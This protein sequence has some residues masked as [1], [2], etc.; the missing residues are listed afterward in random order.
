MKAISRTFMVLVLLA[1]AH[2]LSAQILKPVSWSYGSKKLSATEAVVFM[3]A[4]IEPGWHLYS[5][6]VKEGGPVKTTFSFTPAAAYVLKGATTEPKPITRKE[7]VFDMEV[8]FFENSVVFQQK[9]SLKAPQ[10]TIKGAVE[11]M[12]C[13]DTQCLPPTTQEFSITIR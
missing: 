2:S 13:N 8:S 6:K 12:V 7:E 5:Q 9:V 1:A 11:F 4:T 3:K 10:A